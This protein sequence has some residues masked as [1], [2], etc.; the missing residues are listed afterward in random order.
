[1]LLKVPEGTDCLVRGQYALGHP[2]TLGAPQKAG[3]GPPVARGRESLA[4]V[5]QAE[6]ASATATRPSDTPVGGR[7]EMGRIRSTNGDVDEFAMCDIN[8]SSGMVPRLAEKRAV[9]GGWKRGGL[10]PEV[11][12]GPRGGNSG[13]AKTD[14]VQRGV[15]PYSPNRPWLSVWSRRQRMRGFKPCEAL[16]GGLA[17][18]APAM[19]LAGSLLEPS[20]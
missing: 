10:R 18:P 15:A 9:E 14:A 2:H 8:S 13:K 3:P 4:R 16:S 20:G 11:F 6:I 7:P 19:A 12:P 5:S 1:M 17:Q